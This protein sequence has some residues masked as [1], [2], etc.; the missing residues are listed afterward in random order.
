MKSK[1][2]RMLRG[3]ALLASILLSGALAGGVNAIPTPTNNVALSPTN[4]VALAGEKISWPLATV[5]GL[6]GV[7][8]TNTVVCEIGGATYGSAVVVSNELVYTTGSNIGDLYGS[9]GCDGFVASTN[10]IKDEIYFTIAD[11]GE[12]ATPLATVTVSVRVNYSTTETS[13]NMP[14]IVSDFPVTADCTDDITL[15]VNGWEAG[16]DRLSSVVFQSANYLNV[17]DAFAGTPFEFNLESVGM[18]TTADGTP[19][20]WIVAEESGPDLHLIVS[21]DDGTG[22][23]MTAA[24]YISN[25]VNVDTVLAAYAAQPYKVDYTV[26]SPDNTNITDTA[27]VNFSIM[28]GGSVFKPFIQYVV[29]NV[30]SSK[31]TIALSDVV[32]NATDLPAGWSVALTNAAPI[33]MDP[34]YPNYSYWETLGS[35]ESTEVVSNDIVYTHAVSSDAFRYVSAKLT[36]YSSTNQVASNVVSETYAMIRIAL[37][38]E[39]PS[40][41][42]ATDLVFTTTP[43]AANFDVPFTNGITQLQG[44]NVAVTG[45]WGFAVSVVADNAEFE[46]YATNPEDIRRLNAVHPDDW[47]LFEEDDSII[48][49]EQGG[50]VEY[51]GVK[52]VYTAPRGFEGTD[53]FTYTITDNTYGTDG[54]LNVAQATVTIIIPDADPDPETI[55]D[56]S[57]GSARPEVDFEDIVVEAGDYEIIYLDSDTYFVLGS[58][59]ANGT[60]TWDLREGYGQTNAHNVLRGWFAYTPDDGFVGL[61]SVDVQIIKGGIWSKAGKVIFNVKNDIDNNVGLE[62]QPVVDLDGNSPFAQIQPGSWVRVWVGRDANGSGLTKFWNEWLPPADTAAS[63][64]P[65]SQ[66]V[67]SFADRNIFLPGGYYE[68]W[69]R[70]YNEDSGYADWYLARSFTIEGAAPEAVQLISPIDGEVVLNDDVEYVWNSDENANW[71]QLWVG[72]KVGSETVKFASQW[73]PSVE[74]GFVMF[75]EFNHITGSDYEW[76]VRPWGPDG[77]GAWSLESDG[78]FTT[79]EEL[80]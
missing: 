32:L 76:Y 41:L 78:S 27:T 13:T 74:P 77:M 58:Q 45:N 25:E 17:I 65:R 60:I 18:V 19:A 29:P 55:F 1:T 47:H 14:L 72:R 43:F 34:E 9:M 16:T 3:K 79:T 80:P 71:Y 38:A 48:V 28:H 39:T 11:F 15:V 66:V 20:P 70:T 49:T 31:V 30:E 53:S 40:K 75:D 42:E 46:A 26:V 52:F 67:F 22:T 61:D 37:A 73:W 69:V 57:A 8:A 4:G 36:T 62:R 2:K 50:T 44:T 5:Y 63:E 7:D 56:T 35:F 51:N 6:L 54:S 10:Q 12:C 21:A 68:I 64:F 24:Y 33:V 23:N 59:P